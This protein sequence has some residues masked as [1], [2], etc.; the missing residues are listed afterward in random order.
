[1]VSEWGEGKQFSQK[2][3]RDWGKRKQMLDGQEASQPFRGGTSW[4]AKLTPFLSS[5][6]LIETPVCHPQQFAGIF[7]AAFHLDLL[8]LSLTSTIFPGG[9]ASKESA[10]NSGDLGL[11]PGL[12]RSPG[13]GNGYP[14]QDSGLEYSMDCTVHG[15]TKSRAGLSDFSLSTIL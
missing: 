6:I 5:W 12:G 1:M 7:R 2:K 9:S 8:S 15:I 4:Y 13:E 11:I 10:C 3:I 14:L